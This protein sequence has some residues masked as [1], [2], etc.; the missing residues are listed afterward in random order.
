MPELALESPLFME[1]MAPPTLSL[2]K[3]EGGNRM[4]S[5]KSGICHLQLVL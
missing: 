3:W 2:L 5:L 4:T 1:K